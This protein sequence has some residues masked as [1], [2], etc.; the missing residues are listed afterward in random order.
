MNQ[1]LDYNNCVTITTCNYPL[2]LV[3]PFYMTIEHYRINIA[4]IPSIIITI[5]HYYYYHYFRYKF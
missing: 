2:L 3:I 1:I 5:N 4:I